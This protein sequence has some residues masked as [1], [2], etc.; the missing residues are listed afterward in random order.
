MIN[1]LRPI[2]LDFLAAVCIAASPDV[3]L[4]PCL[5]LIDAT[6]PAAD[7]RQVMNLARRQP[8]ISNLRIV[9]LSDEFPG[10]LRG[11]WCRARHDLLAG[12]SHPVQNAV[13]ARAACTPERRAI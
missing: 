8:L 2:L 6:V 7:V 1:N 10:N 12:C 11:R 3:R 5:L 9:I 13:P 4:R